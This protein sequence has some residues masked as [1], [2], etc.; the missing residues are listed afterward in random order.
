MEKS[1][2]SS[3]TSRRSEPRRAGLRC[4]GASAARVPQLGSLAKA[5]LLRSVS[6]TSLYASPP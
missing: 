6:R 1:D 3:V 2:C 4:T 5:A